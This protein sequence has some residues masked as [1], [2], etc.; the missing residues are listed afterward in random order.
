[1]IQAT[2]LEGSEGK[3]PKA[4]LD[5]TM[6]GTQSVVDQA[7]LLEEPVTWPILKDVA[8]R[9]DAARIYTPL[10]PVHAE[11]EGMRTRSETYLLSPYPFPR[12]TLASY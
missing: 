10:A 12:V 8:S 3:F 6:A 4:M 1:V 7:P 11:N 9:P 2:T 5:F